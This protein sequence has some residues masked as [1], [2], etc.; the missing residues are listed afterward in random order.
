MAA[1]SQHHIGGLEVAMDH[2][3][4]MCFVESV[5]DLHAQLDNTIDG[6]G[7]LSDP[8]L[9]RLAFDVFHDDE[10][11]L[12][13]RLTDLMNDGDIRVVDRRRGVGLAQETLEPARVGRFSGD[14]LDRDAAVK[15]L[16][17]REI[18][19]THPARADLLQNPVV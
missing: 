5:G 3:S 18:H 19:L 14:D 13:L 2:P 8:L 16:V 17:L 4:G 10:G 7:P 15:F 12:I 9:Q 11:D 1:R 6:K